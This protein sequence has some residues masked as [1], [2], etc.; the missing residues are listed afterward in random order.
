MRRGPVTW[1]CYLLLGFFTFT[2]TIQGNVLP[3]IKAGL[4]LSY[5]IASLHSSAVAA[6]M[7][8][9]GLL[10]DRFVRR[11]GRGFG[12]RLGT[13]AVIA[14]LLLMAGAPSV[15]VSL[16][17]CLLIGVLGALIPA[18][19]FAVLSDVQGEY[20]ASAYNEFERGFVRLR[21]HGPTVDEPLLVAFLVLALLHRLRRGRRPGHCCRLSQRRRTAAGRT[22]GKRRRPPPT[23]VLGLLVLPR[24]VGRDRVLRVDLGADVSREVRWPLACGRGRSHRVVFARDACRQD[25]RRTP[26]AR[27]PDPAP[28]H[29]RAVPRIDRLCAL[30]GRR[31]SSPS[32]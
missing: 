13:A 18:I 17:G 28:V 14:G 7:V 32:R 12:L 29:W 2:L 15:W 26:G 3:F 21:H 4:D 5:G 27:R 6:G 25:R 16:A 24:R 9:V 23:G 1:Y 19:V 10:G 31:R 11:A 30:L 8:L 22:N 20:R